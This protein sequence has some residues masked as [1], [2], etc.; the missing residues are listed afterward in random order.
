MPKKKKKSIKYDFTSEETWR[1]FRIMAEFVEGFEVLSR[2]GPAVSIFGSAQLKPSN[3]YYKLAIETSKLLAKNDFS[4]ITGAG[5]GIM[6]AANKGAK[7]GKGKSIGLN[8]EVPLDQK[9]NP[10]VDLLLD[11]H[12]FFVRKVMFVRYAK[13]FV[14]FPGGYGTHDELFESL[15]LILTLK[16]PK[17]PVIL[18]G[19]KYWRGFMHYLK[20]CVMKEGCITKRELELLTVVNTPREVLKV[21]QDFYQK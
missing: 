9:P 1:I 19:R 5:P 11:F 17:F 6:E 20:T 7:L 15:N 16:I 10:H 14:I 2:V 13:A 18:V 3:R 21:I 4:I 12:Y 8:I